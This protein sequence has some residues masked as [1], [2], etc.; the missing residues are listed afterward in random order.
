[1]GAKGMKLLLAAVA[2]LGLTT[3]SQAELLI[4]AE[5]DGGVAVPGLPGYTGY[6]VTLKSN[7]PANPPAAWAGSFDGPMNQLKVAS[8][9]DTPTMT[10]ASAL[11]GDLPK[12]SHL[13]LWDAD[14]LIASAPTESGLHLDGI[15]GISVGARQQDLPLAY[16]VIPDGEQVVMTG[17]TS[18]PNGLFAFPTDLV[19]PEPASLALLALGGVVAVLRRRR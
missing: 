4:W 7:D 9:L 15:F 16:L 10:L 18:D 3:A 8:V 1:M 12:D 11:G 2:V 19:I 13:L 6:T 5:H 17:E 14:L